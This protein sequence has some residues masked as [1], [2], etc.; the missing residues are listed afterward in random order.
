[1]DTL[2]LN[3]F[4]VLSRQTL[5]RACVKTINYQHLKN[6]RDSKWTMVFE[7]GSSPKGSWRS[8]YKSPIEKRVGDLQWRIVHGILATNRHKVLLNVSDDKGCPFYQVSETVCRLFIR[9]GP[10]IIF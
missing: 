7:S 10:N 1:M 6:V 4:S 5:Y 2:E 9:A 8:L 3:I